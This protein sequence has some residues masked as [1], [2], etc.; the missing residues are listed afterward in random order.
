MKDY[1]GKTMF[2]GIDVHKKTYAV[3]CIC[4]GE[5]IKKDT[6]QASPVGLSE[7]LHKYFLNA[8]FKTVYEAGFSGFSL[9]RYLLAKRIDNIVV[10]AASVEVS[11]RNRVKTDKRDS[12]QLAT[13]L[14]TNRLKGIY[15][16]TPQREA[17]REVSRLRAKIAKDKRRVGNRLKSLLYRQG[18]LGAKKDQVVSKKWMDKVSKYKCDESI[19]YCIQLCIDE[20][21]FLREKLKESDA[22]LANQAIA[23]KE[24]ESVYR[25]A[26]GIGVI[27][28]RT[29]A[30]E[31]EDMKHFSNEKHLFSFTGL[32]PREYSSGENK[33]LGH[34]SR[35]GRSVL[36]NTLIQAAWI[37]ISKDP[38]LKHIYEKIAC[39]AGK[40]RAIVGVGRRLIGQI[41]ACFRSN[42]LYYFRETDVASICSTTGEIALTVDKEPVA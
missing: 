34:I 22:R 41:R 31:L 33:R 2:V 24:L 20:W 4:E 16:P 38:S 19:Q 3:T 42:T 28:A 14:S 11:A 36:R 10:H 40:K 29:L 23:D 18:L 21:L 32:T 27:H 6:L 12:L 7:Y 37:A 39:R 1:T 8:K 35:Q 15:V 17:Y 13:Q 25:S 30:N 9:H 5:V 26:P